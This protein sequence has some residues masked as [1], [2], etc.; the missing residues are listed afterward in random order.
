MH[1][2]DPEEG[3]DAIDT[4]LT[5]VKHDEDAEGDIEEYIAIAKS[6]LQA[7][8]NIHDAGEVSSLSACFGM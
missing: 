6:L 2:Q 5:C 3:L 1:I 4:L 7:G 8:A